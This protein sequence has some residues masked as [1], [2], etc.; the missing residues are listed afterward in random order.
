MNQVQGMKPSK[1]GYLPD[2]PKR[3]DTKK[4]ATVE[5]FLIGAT[6]VLAVVWFLTS[7]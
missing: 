7:R 4:E 2:L 3:R 1:T 6:I 5:Y